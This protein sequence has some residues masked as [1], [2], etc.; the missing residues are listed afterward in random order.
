MANIPIIGKV[1]VG[2]TTKE[3]SDGYVNIGGVWKP[4]VKTYVNVN[5]VWMSAWKNLTTWK[6]YTVKQ[7]TGAPYKTVKSALKTGDFTANDYVQGASNYSFDSS[8]GVY[9]LTNSRQIEVQGLGNV[10]KFHM[11]GKT[12]TSGAVMYEWYTGNKTSILNYNMKYYEWT[13]TPSTTQSRGDYISEV[14][15]EDETAYPSNGV[16]TDGYWYVK[17]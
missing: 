12:T 5:G 9:A 3:L 17:Q 2:G 15:S 16:H 6:K 4:I 13:S 10:Y 11:F 14:S 7:T 8:T 1:T